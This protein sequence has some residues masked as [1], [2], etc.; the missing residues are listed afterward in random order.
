MTTYYWEKPF[1]CRPDHGQF[2]A[3]HDQEALEKRPGKAILLYR[4][5]DTEDGMP[6]VILY[7]KKIQINYQRSGSEMLILSKEIP[8]HM[9]IVRFR[10]CQKNF[11]TMSERYRAVR[12]NMQ[13][14]MDICYWCHHRFIDGE[15]MALA[16]PEKGTNKVLCQECASQLLE[17][18]IPLKSEISRRIIK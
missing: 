11:I 6:F 1:G 4:E 7:E 12:A 10:W 8:K 5:S 13:N 15:V 14:R 17:E 9:K 18:P 2:E 3:Y 16:A